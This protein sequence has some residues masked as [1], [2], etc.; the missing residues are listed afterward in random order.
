MT[1]FCTAAWASFGDRPAIVCA[2]V[3]RTYSELSVSVDSVAAHLASTGL[4]HGDVLA[5]VSPN[6]PDYATVLLAAIKLGITV[7]PMNP[8]LTAHEMAVQ[9]RDSDTKMVVFAPE[10]EEARAAAA[11][12]QPTCGTLTLGD[13]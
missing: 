4:Q 5:L 2:G 3:T 10:C 12:S 7:S 9:L 11:E 13:E 8:M 6:H 1:Q